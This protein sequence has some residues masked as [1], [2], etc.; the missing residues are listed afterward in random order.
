M[1][2]YVFLIYGKIYFE[3]WALSGVEIVQFKSDELNTKN[4]YQ[5]FIESLLNTH[6]LSGEYN[7]NDFNITKDME[8]NGV[9]QISGPTFNDSPSHFNG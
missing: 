7:V 3:K 2:E 5:K 6:G 1:F 9:R 4:L 8:I